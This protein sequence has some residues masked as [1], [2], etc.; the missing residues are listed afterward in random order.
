M[1]TQ[2]DLKHVELNAALHVYVFCVTGSERFGAQGRLLNLAY[3][4]FQ[5]AEPGVIID[6]KCNRALN[7]VR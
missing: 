3:L 1:L 5:F 2:D 7:D 4:V 6:L